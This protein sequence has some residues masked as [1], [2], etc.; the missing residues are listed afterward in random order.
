[1]VHSF[2]LNQ[3][4][5]AARDRFEGRLRA[6]SGDR[7]VER[8]VLEWGASAAPE[9]RRIAYRGGR[10]RGEA[11]LALADAHGAWIEWRD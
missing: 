2:T 11:L 9:L 4:T 7:P 5:A 8:L 6:A 1:M 3:F 10:R